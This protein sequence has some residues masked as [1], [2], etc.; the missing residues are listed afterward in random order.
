[1]TCGSRSHRLLI[2]VCLLAV[3]VSLTATPSI[4]A[5]KS[6]GKIRMSL[7]DSDVT[8]LDPIVPPDNMS[9]WTMLH[10]Y[11]QLVRVGKDGLSVEPDAADSWKT[12]ADGKT[13]TFHIRD[14]IKFSDGTPLTAGDAKFSMQRAISK[15]SIFGDSFTLVDS[16]TAPDDHTLVVTLKKP[17][18]SFLAYVSLYVASITP[19]KQTTAGGKDFWEHPI[20][21]GPYVLTEWVKNDHLT[22]KRNPNY[23]QKP[24]PYVDELRFDVLTDDNTRMLKLRSGELDIAT[25]V[26]PNQVEALKKTK[27]LSVAL[28]P[29]MRFDYV[30]VNHAKK[31]FDDLRVRR[32]LNYVVNRQAILKSV[33]F[34]YGQV[35]TSMLPPMLY[36]NDQL[37]PYPLDAARAKALL[38]EAGYGNGL[39][40]EI[41]I[42]SGDNQASQIATIMKDEFKAV[43][44]D[45][46]VTVLDVGAVRARRKSG[47]F[48]MIKGYYT[49]DV[50]DPDELIAFGIDY[51]GGAVAKW[52]SFKNERI[53]KLAEAAATEMNAAK[54]KAMILE[55]QKVAYDQA[56]VIPLY[57][58]ANR[59]AMWDHVHDFKQLQTANY[60]L[61]ETWV[62]K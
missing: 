12:S 36:W 21:S 9:I 17:W 7:A 28:F 15:D 62:S 51:A 6:G 27:G 37:K 8:S 10:I 11:D 39:S 24:F 22:L 45:L 53:S 13:W 33:L 49:S 34:G 47:D 19:E 4:S 18:A 41:L 29:Q 57:Y 40:T 59:T 20:G 23:W 35:A 26:P 2:A 16:I 54:R 58:A 14:G 1:M 50:V 32:A 61:W 55:I 56:P 5:P 48:Q 43:G 38:K 25:N 46:K 30:Y 52:I 31:P 44:V 42:V 3:L 60:R